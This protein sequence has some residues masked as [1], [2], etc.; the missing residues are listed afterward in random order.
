MNIKR[1]KEQILLASLLFGMFFGAGNLIFPVSLGQ[2][3]GNKVFTSSLGFIISG[4]GLAALAVVYVAKSKTK[5]LEE[6]L[7]PYGKIYARS[8]TILLLLTIGPFFALPRTATVP[9][10]VSIKILFENTNHTLGLFIYSLIFF[11]I[12]LVLSLKPTKIKDFIGKYINPIFLVC[13]SLFFI[14]FFIK[15]MGT[16]KDILAQADYRINPFLSGFSDGYHTM[17]VLAALSFGF[18]IIN[19]TNKDSS[20]KNKIIDIIMASIIASILMAVIYLILSY[21]GASSRN[22]FEASENGG[23]AL[24]H[25]FKYYF[26]EI[27]TLF[28]ALTITFACLKTAIGL[29]V[30]TS[31]YF[32]EIIPKISYKNF[33]IIFATFSFLISNIGLSNIIQYS[34][35]ILNFLYPLAIMH[36]LVGLTIK[37]KHKVYNYSL[38]TFT[39]IASTIELIK[40]FPNLINTN[41]YLNS[42]IDFYTTKLFLANVGLSW[43]NFTIVGFIVGMFIKKIIV[44]K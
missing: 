25:I 43:I 26:K 21:I 34:I 37:T 30:A 8:F 4:V 2:L 28:F 32:N 29:I 20:F 3:S 18:V 12:A 23:I 11:S 35:P 19:S 17:D 15:T 41:A 6:L 9:Y 33:A 36:V 24:G 38:L 27:G 44:D 31:T 40:S 39:L 5:S 1:L 13:L 14:A 7:S 16:P 42:F 22:I 10:E